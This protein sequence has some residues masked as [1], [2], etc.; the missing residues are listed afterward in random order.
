MACLRCEVRAVDDFSWAVTRSK[1]D[2]TNGFTA[3]TEKL[4]HDSHEQLGDLM[5]HFVRRVGELPGLVKSDID[6][7][8]RRVP[9][10]SSQRWAC[11]IAFLAFAQVSAQCPLARRFQFACCSAQVMAAVH[12]ACPFGAVG[13]VHGW[14]R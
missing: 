5:R 3:P 2:S 9:V 1:G 8:F 4:R 14:E 6:A 12:I 11:G 7:A 13:F 10:C